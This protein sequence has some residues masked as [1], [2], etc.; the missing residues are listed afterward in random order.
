M[1]GLAALDSLF[2]LVV[3][4]GYLLSFNA[5]MISGSIHLNLWIIRNR[6]DVAPDVLRGLGHTLPVFGYRALLVISRA[7]I[8][9]YVLSRLSRRT[10]H[11]NASFMAF[12]LLA[13]Q[14]V[15]GPRYRF[16][17]NG[18][19]YSLP[20]FTVIF[21]LILLSLIAPSI[22]WGLRRG[23]R[24]H[25]LSFGWMILAIAL[26]LNQ[27]S[28]VGIVTSWPAFYILAITVR[29]RWEERPRPYLP[30]A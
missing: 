23:L 11:V 5:F 9:G 25:A 18:A 21:P 13:S 30:T 3:P 16:Y 10:V 14:A 19:T 17:V 27:I 4:I 24:G 29:Q 15:V 12:V 7:W 6:R 20:F 2:L 8:A 1:E 26:I 28:P 22:Y